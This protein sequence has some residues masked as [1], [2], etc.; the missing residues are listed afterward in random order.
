MR[1]EEKIEFILKHIG[2]N[3]WK[4]SDEDRKTLQP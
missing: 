1:R 2:N 4:L 3:G